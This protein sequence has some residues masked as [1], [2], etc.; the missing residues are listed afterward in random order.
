MPI[1]EWGVDKIHDLQGTL[2]GSNKAY[3]ELLNEFHIC[4]FK[5]HAEEKC[6][7]VAGNLCKVVFL[8]C[9]VQFQWNNG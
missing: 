9:I 2:H 8:S 3:H 1:T 6:C 5:V 4:L 7:T